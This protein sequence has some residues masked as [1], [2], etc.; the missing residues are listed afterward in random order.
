MSRY[1]KLPKLILADN[2]VVYAECEDCKA[3]TSVKWEDINT[4]HSG[5]CGGHGPDEYCYC[6]GDELSVFYKCDNCKKNVYIV[7]ESS[8][9]Y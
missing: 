2:V 5:G 7:Y 4:E 9:T 6:S 1:K 8:F 3:V